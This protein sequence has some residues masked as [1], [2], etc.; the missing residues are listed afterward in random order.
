MPCNQRVRCRAFCAVLKAC[1][2]N[3]LILFLF[4]TRGRGVLQLKGTFFLCGGN[5]PRIRNLLFYSRS[6]FF[7]LLYGNIVKGVFVVP[8]I[9]VFGMTVI[10]I[11]WAMVLIGFFK[12]S[13]LQK[14]G[15]FVFFVGLLIFI[16]SYISE[17]TK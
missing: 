16:G 2:N 8:M 1:T 14:Q 6:L 10:A 17:L 15:Y 7:V 3:P 11:S 4:R 5:V 9:R 13:D 12:N